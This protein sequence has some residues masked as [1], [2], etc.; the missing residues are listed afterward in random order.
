VVIAV[1][2]GAATLRE[3]L[4]S[5]ATQAHPNVEAVVI[6][7]GSTDGTLEIVRDSP[8]PIGYW[9]SAPD[10]G[11]YDAWNK[12][13]AH[14]SGEW[15][16]FLGADDRFAYANA[17]S[18]LVRLGRMLNADLV[19]G[20]V[21]ICDARGRLVRVIG[22]EWNWRTMKRHQAIAHPGTI[23]RV[24]LFAE[25]G[26]FAHNLRIVGDY[27]FLL[28]LGTSARTG[29]LNRMIVLMGASGA[30]RTD[31]LRVLLESW[32]V[33]ARHPEIGPMAATRNLF[34]AA[35]KAAARSV[36]GLS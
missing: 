20:R 21:G 26:G 24:D 15:V 28:R 29:F 36:L 18:D 6:D 34:I 9:E 33:Q 16:C 7:G 12:A 13:L 11:I 19:C 27:E 3:C 22:R 23:H 31:I 5:I 25:Y 4:A 35:L 17:L 14:V 10:R 32:R 1:R 30:S 8:F 2:N